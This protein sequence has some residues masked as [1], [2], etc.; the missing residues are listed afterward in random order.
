VKEFER[1]AAAWRNPASVVANWA[2]AGEIDSRLL[3]YRVQGEWWE[4]LHEQR[5]TLFVTRETEHLVIALSHPAERPQVTFLPLPHPSGIAADR[6]SMTVHV[7]STRN[8]NQIV[9][10]RPS[11]HDGKPMLPAD[12]RFFPG[13]LYLHDL[14]LV[15]S[16][17][18]GN[19]VGHNAIVRFEQSGAYGPVWWPQSIDGPD[20]PRFERNYLQLNSIAAGETLSQSFFSAS[21]EQPSHRRPGHV[22]YPVDRRGVIFSG[23]TREPVVRGLTRPHSARLRSSSLWVDDS[24]Y[25]T[26]GPCQ[27]G[28][29][30]PVMK[31]PGWTRG[32]AF[33][34]RTAFIATSHVIP[35]FRAYAPGID[36]RRTLC[37][38]HAVDV[39][40]GRLRGSLTWPSGNQIFGIDWM[41]DRCSE[42][43][44]FIVTERSQRRSRALFYDLRPFPPPSP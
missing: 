40:T 3:G 14:A 35:R 5:I 2:Q 9:S 1:H 10:L 41:P 24:G 4:S 8:P 18:H 17:L 27:D 6:A 31:L 29:L 22:N 25:G 12:S 36:P 19:A 38:V 23:A 20:S 28:R 33:V 11:S 15:G 37:G 7:A 21:S 32:L 39:P 30:V 44:P 16:A 42:G 34:D 13:R 26:F 43:L